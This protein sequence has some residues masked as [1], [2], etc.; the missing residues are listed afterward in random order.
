MAARKFIEV[1][2]NYMAASGAANAT[3]KSHYAN[4]M[5]VQQEFVR[6]GHTQNPCQDSQNN[7]ELACLE[8]AITSVTKC[9]YRLSRVASA[10]LNWSLSG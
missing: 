2:T 1:E 10:F 9:R 8:Q 5:L 3:I 6:V 7:C 4:I